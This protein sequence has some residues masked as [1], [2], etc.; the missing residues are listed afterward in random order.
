MFVIFP[1]LYSWVGKKITVNALHPG[2]V[3]TEFG[4]F[5]PC[6]FFRKLASWVSPVFLKVEDDF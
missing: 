4:R 5:L 3:H 6:E 1:P 2:L